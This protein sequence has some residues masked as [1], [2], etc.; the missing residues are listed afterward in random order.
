MQSEDIA[1][2]E[3]EALQAEGRDRMNARLQVW[4][5]FLSLVLAFGLA[6]VQSGP[7][8]YVAGLFPVLACCLARHVRHSEDA[9]RQVRKYLYQVEKAASYEGYEHYSRCQPRATHGGYL[10]AL[11]DALLVTQMLALAVV[12]IRLASDQVTLLIIV[13]VIGLEVAAMFLTWRWLKK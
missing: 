3:Y 8:A 9:L 4:T 6:G 11:R 13:P 2:L 1:K 12:V 7:A 5:I 10:D